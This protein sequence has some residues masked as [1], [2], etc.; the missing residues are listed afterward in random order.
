MGDW[1]VTEGSGWI[2]IPDFGRINPRRDN[3]DGGRYYF[4]A[5]TPDGGYADARGPEVTEGPETWHYEP[6]QPFHLRDV[7]TGKV[8][9]VVIS[10]L[11]GGRYAVKSR[12][13]EWPS[14]STSGGWS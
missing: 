4:T 8:L 11:A 12:P 2:E 14:P 13:G 9:E 10:L 3:V 5:K 1:V 7:T 6:D